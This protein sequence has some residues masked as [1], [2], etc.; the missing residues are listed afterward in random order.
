MVD[1]PVRRLKTLLDIIHA[2]A[3]TRAALLV[4]LASAL[5]PWHQ[6]AQQLQQYQ[7]HDH[8][9]FLVQLLF[10][11]WLQ[12]VICVLAGSVIM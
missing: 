6:H 12:P 3:N 7:V 5:L 11:L 4:A 2:I 10:T 8:Q 9:L 1:R